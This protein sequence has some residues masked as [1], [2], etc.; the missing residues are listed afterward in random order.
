[1]LVVVAFFV[2]IIGTLGAL[3][4]HGFRRYIAAA[5]TAEARM[6][7]G[8]I[9][10]DAAV[11]FDRERTDPSGAVFSS[12]CASASTPVPAS[13]SSIKGI[14]YQSAPSEWLV[15]KTSDAGFACLGFQMLEP[16]YY[17]Y[18]YK[19]SGTNKPGDQFRAIAQG[20]LNGDGSL[21]TFVLEGHV[22][23]NGTLMV[24]PSLLETDPDE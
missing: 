13:P 9:A 22:A 11:A 1:M 14:K 4:I 12:M 19:A 6:N 7:V 23:P 21:S 24:S 16:Q 8:L 2:L 18:D 5:K 17:Q 20:D 15:D 10:K 3:A